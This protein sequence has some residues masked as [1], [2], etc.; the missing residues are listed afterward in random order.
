MLYK[1][2]EKAYA[3][4][5]LEA[6]S[7]LGF[8]GKPSQ[9]ADLGLYCLDLPQLSHGNKPIMIPKYKFSLLILLRNL[10]LSKTKI[11]FVGLALLKKSTFF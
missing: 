6:L 9:R 11:R 3:Q 10:A 4:H 2:R 8:L 7:L 5:K 1:L